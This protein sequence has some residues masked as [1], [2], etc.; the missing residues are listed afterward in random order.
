[1]KR[2]TAVLPALV[3]GALMSLQPLKAHA[4]PVSAAVAWAIWSF[5]VGVTTG[6]VAVAIATSPNPAPEKSAGVDPDPKKMYP[7]GERHAALAGNV[8]H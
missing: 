4:D 1:M 7:R 8:R 5:L 2:T 6:G 3:L